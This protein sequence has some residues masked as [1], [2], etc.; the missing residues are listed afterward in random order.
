MPNTRTWYEASTSGDQ[1]LVIEE[2]TGRSVAV[3]YD[4]ADAVLIAAAP[5]LLNALEYLIRVDDELEY[6][7]AVKQAREAIAKAKGE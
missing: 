5:E 4:K 2:T 3:A 7:S 1:G 6:E